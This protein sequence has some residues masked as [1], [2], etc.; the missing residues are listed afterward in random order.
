MNMRRP[1]AVDCGRLIN[2]A[3]AL[4]V[5]GILLVRAI[6]REAPWPAY[7]MGVGFLVFGGYRLYL[8]TQYRKGG[9]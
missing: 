5:G 9:R 3:L 6:L 4:G 1:S 7:L 8:Y 2:M